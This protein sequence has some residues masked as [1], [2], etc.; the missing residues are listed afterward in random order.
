MSK[1]L[2]HSK[3]NPKPTSLQSGWWAALFI[4]PCLLGLVIF[5]YLPTLASFTLSFTRWNFLGTP[6]WVGLENYQQLTT[7]PLFWKVLT[8]T[9]N[10]VAISG[11]LEVSLG[12]VLAI[13]LN[14]PIKGQSLFRTAYFLPF[15][16]PLIGVALVWGWIYQPEYGL[17]N[18]LLSQT[19]LFEIF[20][21]GKP[22]SWLYDPQFAMLAIIILRVW[23]NIGYN[24]VIFL[25]GLQA[26]PSSVN[27]SVTIDG[28]N[29]WQRFWQVTLPM[30]SP[31]VF[32]VLMVSL[33][34]AFQAF[35]TIYLLTQGGPQHSTA[36]LVY[37]VFKNAF[38]FYQ[39]GTASAVAYVL[40]LFILL[41]TLLQWQLRKKWV[42]HES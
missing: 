27:E 10:F 37:W 17:L 4:L 31:T 40:F 11:V 34:N 39:I 21:N 8:N 33:I 20:N 38:E 24:M 5:T 22:I 23:K 16:T 32:F 36:V 1:A 14:Q 6:T 3:K 30:I 15:V 7:D 26:I 29:P 9:F 13:L 19:Y 12:L 2:K 25:A 28:A 41:L 42:L 35:D 18:W